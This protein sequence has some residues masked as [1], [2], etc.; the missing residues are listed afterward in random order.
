MYE[1]DGFSFFREDIKPDAPMNNLKVK[2]RI[3][4]PKDDKLIDVSF[5]V[6]DEKLITDFIK[7]F[8][9]DTELLKE[10]VT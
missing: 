6:K 7:S 2:L 10:E 8:K 5:V 9:I 4:S 3:V 1:R